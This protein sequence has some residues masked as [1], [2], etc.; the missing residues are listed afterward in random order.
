VIPNIIPIII[1]T[2]SIAATPNRVNTTKRVVAASTING[3][4]IQ[5]NGDRLYH[6]GA[7]LF[8]SV[9]TNSWRSSRSLVTCE[10]LT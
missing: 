2:S 8:S 1:V 3:D 5:W 7:R 4:T 6:C 9:C 10:W